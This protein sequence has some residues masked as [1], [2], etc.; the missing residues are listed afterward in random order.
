MDYP[1]DKSITL[2]IRLLKKEAKIPLNPPRGTLGVL[3]L[4][5]P[6]PLTLIPPAP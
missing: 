3:G 2:W 1:V 6:L 4:V 5:V